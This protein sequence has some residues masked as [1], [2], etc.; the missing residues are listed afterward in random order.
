VSQGRYAE[1]YFM[2]PHR[3]TLERWI[4]DVAEPVA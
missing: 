3:Q 1:E 4:A 2:K